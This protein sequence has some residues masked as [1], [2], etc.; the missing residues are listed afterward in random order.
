MDASGM[1]RSAWACVV[2]SQTVMQVQPKRSS[3]RTSLRIQVERSLS[4]RK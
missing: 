3:V 2:S 1:S 4:S